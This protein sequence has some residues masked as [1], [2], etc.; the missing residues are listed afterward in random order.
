MTC[1]PA[2]VCV[3]K[4]LEDDILRSLRRIT[5]AIDLHSR[6]LANNFGL[7]GPQLVCLRVIASRG[8]ITPTELAHEV[9]LSQ[10]TVTGIVDRLAARQLVTRDRNSDDR[11]VVTISIDA[12]GKAL[13]DEAPPPLQER[14]VDRLA[15]LS[16]LEQLT[17]RA[18][19]QRVVEMMDG[20]DIE[21]AP[22]LTTSPAAQ[23]PEE[24]REVAD[25]APSDIAP[26]E[27]V[28]DNTPMSDAEP[29]DA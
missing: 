13:I 22:V 14:F 16:E 12:A 10:A 11:R 7:T 15:C 3:T 19:L 9:S 28:A 2:G 17:I 5:R 8:N 4:A 18:T 27:R 20:E 6:W 21:A 26:L 24:L 1:Q 29:D 23:S 25:P